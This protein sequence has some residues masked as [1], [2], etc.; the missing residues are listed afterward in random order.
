[1]RVVIEKNNYKLHLI[2][3]RWTFKE[4]LESSCIPLSDAPISY[5]VIYTK[6]GRALLKEDNIFFKGKKI[7]MK[8]NNSQGSIKET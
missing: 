2:K 4:I 6:E 8:K 5:S 1:M 7:K 3:T